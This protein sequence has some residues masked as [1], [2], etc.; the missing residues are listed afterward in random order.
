MYRKIVLFIL[1]AL[2]ITLIGCKSNNY[3]ITTCKAEPIDTFVNESE[4]IVTNTILIYHKDGF[5]KKTVMVQE[6][7]LKD[8][9]IKDL[10]LYSV[11]TEETF[12]N[13]IFNIKGFEYSTE[14]TDTS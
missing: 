2:I 13:E 3:S 7:V 10:K 11:G 4:I 8:G 12:K 9:D 14:F 6:N 5:V 1:I